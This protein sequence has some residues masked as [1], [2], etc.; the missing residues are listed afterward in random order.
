[1]DNQGKIILNNENDQDWKERMKSTIIFLGSHVWNLVCNGY[2]D[3]L[4]AYKELQNNGQELNE[5]FCSLH[6]S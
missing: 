5:I 3:T 1:M 6:D 2:A 4:A